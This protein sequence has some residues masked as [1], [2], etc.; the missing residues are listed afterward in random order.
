M[1]LTPCGTF[2][3][4]AICQVLID[5]GIVMDFR[6]PDILR[7]GVAPMCNSYIDI[8]RA[9]NAIQKIMKNE[10]HLDPRWQARN[11]AT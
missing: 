7:A 5:Q 8:W 11:K 4:N 3:R 10:E 1:Q 2:G 6:E 9:V